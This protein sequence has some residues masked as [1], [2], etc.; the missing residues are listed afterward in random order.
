MNSAC[1]CMCVCIHSSCFYIYIDIFKFA[2]NTYGYE[3]ISV[4]K[5]GLIL[6]N[7]MADIA[8]CL[9]IIYMF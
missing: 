9:E 1:P 4:K 6:K 8:D 7:K 5:F 3:N 2:E